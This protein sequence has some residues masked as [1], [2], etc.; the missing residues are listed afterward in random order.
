MDENLSP[1]NDSRRR[2]DA[3]A[4]ELGP[5]KKP[6][7]SLVFTCPTLTIHH[8][9]RLTDPLVSRGRHF[10]RTV[11]ALCN[12]QALIT[13]GLLRIGE[14]ADE[15]EESFTA[16]YVHVMVPSLMT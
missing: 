9:S 3:S 15:P 10:C 8:Y 2:E 6:S 13:N 11:H 14:Q 5:R 16:E 7:A 1:T 4:L 12:I